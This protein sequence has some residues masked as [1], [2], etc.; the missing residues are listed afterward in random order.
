MKINRW[1]SLFI[2]IALYGVGIVLSIKANL[3]IAPWDAFHQGISK[4]VNITLG[5]A[6]MGVGLVLLI[7]NYWFKEK[8]GLGTILNTFGIG[9]VIDLIFYLDLIPTMNTIFSGVVAIIVSL[10]TISLASYFYI[11]AGFGT[12]PRDGLMVGLVKKTKKSTG[13][14]R[15][16]IELTVLIIGFFLGG[17]IGFGT[18]LL[19]L[20]IGP[21]IQFTF[22]HLNF[23][24][25]AV[26]HKY[27]FDKK[28][29]LEQVEKKSC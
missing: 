28:K 17:K 21:A 10:F 20:G 5:Q 12:G 27:F 11:G 29:L 22:K 8:I 14:I 25:G 9:M 2:G 6:S 15:G 7:F 26:E 16:T 4:I 1:V 19:G 23:D 13:L 18:I 3:G 24:V